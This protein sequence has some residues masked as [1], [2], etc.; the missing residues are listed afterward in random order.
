MIR[1][2]VIVAVLLLASSSRGE[3]WPRWRGVRGDGT[4]QGPQIAEKWPDTLPVVWKQKLGPG[5]SGISVAHGKVIT[6]DRPA[7]P[8]EHERIVCFAADSGKLLWEHQYAADYEPIDYKQGPRSQPTIHEGRVYTLGAV[9]H[10]HCLDLADGSVIWKRDLAAENKLKLPEWGLAASPLIVGEQVIV[11][12][13][14][15]KGCYS[16]YDRA[17]GKELW[18]SGDDPAGYSTPRLIR[19]GEHDV[20]IGWTPLHITARLAN[21][22]RELWRVPYKVTYGVSIAD[23]IVQEGIVLVCGYWEGSKAIKL[24]EQPTEATLLWEENKMLRGIMS[25]PLYRD[26]HA[27]LLD[28][29]HGLVCFRLADGKILWTDENRLTK[30]D[31]NPQASLVWLGDSDRALA[32]N[33]EGQLVQLRLTPEKYEELGRVQLVKPT[34]AHPAYADDYVFARDNEQIVCARL[35]P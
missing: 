7:E 33:A 5:Y 13:G 22:G 19:Q 11:H 14:L 1:F 3:D 28:K 27:Y 34:W 30:R 16:S 23:P 9:G 32:L 2:A 21:D 15:P 25:T 4:W 10:L 20:L 31:R 18:R 29:Q 6:I 26:G 17:S 8:A 24:G 35:T 12:A